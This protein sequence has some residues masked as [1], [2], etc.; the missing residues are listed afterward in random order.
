[1]EKTLNGCDNLKKSFFS[2]L[3]KDIFT[4]PL[5]YC[6]AIPV[7]AFYVIFM[8]IPMWG[9]LIAFYEYK[10]LLGISGSKFVGL[11][12]FVEFIKG[13]Y[14]SRVVVNTFMLNLWALVLG[15]PAPIILAL[16]INEVK[17]TI[18]KKVVQTITYVP[19][20]ISLVVICGL[21][22]IFLHP[23]YGVMGFFYTTITGSEM[24]MLAQAA[25]FRPIYTISGIWEAVGWSSIIYLASIAG[26]SQELYEAATID[27][28]NRFQQMWHITISSIAPTII[29]LFIFQIGGMMASGSEKII[30]LYN[31]A[32]Y[33][34][35][36]T[37]GSYI[38]RRGLVEADY[39]LSTAVGLMGSIVNFA[40]LWGT[41]IIA[42]KYS[43]TSLW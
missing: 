37:I 41:N 28:A 11:E 13:P 19:H 38:Y 25:L 14:F 6:F 27:G 4:N 33:E 8:Y 36:D 26:V 29:I 39:S 16:M 5:V 18:F 12:K 30:L 43:E 21:I 23:T 1:M 15:F 24:P 7:I 35:A 32:T 34:T 22:R 2:R 9:S 10:P 42:R 3:K 20:F 40:L 31:P 17:N